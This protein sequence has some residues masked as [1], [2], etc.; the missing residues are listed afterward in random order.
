MGRLVPRYGED[1]RMAW[2]AA[3]LVASLMSA[4]GGLTQL[5]HSA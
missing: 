3:E 4:V 5:T 1:K 2:V